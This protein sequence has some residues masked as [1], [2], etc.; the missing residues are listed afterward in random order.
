MAPECQGIVEF[1]LTSSLQSHAERWCGD[2]QRAPDVTAGQ[3]LAV[4]LI[5]TQFHHFRSRAAE[6]KLPVSSMGKQAPSQTQ[7]LSQS[8]KQRTWR[9]LAAILVGTADGSSVIRLVNSPLNRVVNVKESATIERVTIT[10]GTNTNGA[11]GGI[12]NDGSIEIE[13]STIDNNTA[14]RK[15]SGL[16]D[17]GSDTVILNSTFVGNK[18]SPGGAVSSTGTTDLTHVTIVRNQATS[19]SSAGLISKND[20]TDTD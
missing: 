8:V 2:Y 13:N 19:N 11:G 1:R 17:N 14:G 3:R 10:G 7:R 6:G 4:T 15:G 12:N 16:R 20:D 9:S 5:A 18:A